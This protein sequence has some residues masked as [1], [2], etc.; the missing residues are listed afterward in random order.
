MRIAQDEELP[1]LARDMFASLGRQWEEPG[2][3]DQAPR[4]P[5]FSPY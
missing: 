4:L 1:D 5:S 2:G 3:G